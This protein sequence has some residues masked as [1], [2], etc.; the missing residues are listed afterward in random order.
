[1]ADVDFGTYHHSTP[2]ESKRI[3]KDAERA[4]S[5]L[6]RPL[7]PSGAALRILDA[8]CGLGFL[9]YVAAKCFPKARI[10]GVDLFRRGSMSELSMDKAVKNIK[11]LGNR[12][13][14]FVPQA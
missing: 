7:Y 4:F 14:N 9:I 10:T 6:L 3:R 12:L 1:M 8:G 13:Q 11:S 5:K 2:A